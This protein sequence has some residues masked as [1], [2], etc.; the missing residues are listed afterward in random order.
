M[1]SETVVVEVKG[2]LKLGVDLNGNDS[3]SYLYNE[4]KQIV[5]VVPKSCL[6]YAID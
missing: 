6:I 1:C 5:A 4:D 2:I 3:V